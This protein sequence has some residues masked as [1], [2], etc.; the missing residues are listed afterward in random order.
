MQN[1]TATV[2]SL[3]IERDGAVLLGRRS[4][5]KDHA[6]GEWETIS[7]RVE[8]S[9]TLVEAAQREALEE[10][11]LVVEVL[12]QLASFKFRR[13]TDIAETH[14]VTFHCRVREGSERL[15]D[16]HDRFAW[17]TLEQAKGYGLPEGLLQCIE[18]VLK[19]QIHDA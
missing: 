12:K 1:A 7:C 16:E 10:T 11:G 19:R 17:A 18:T 14:G 2:V 5:T 9:E 13:G 8:A 6:P 4:S 15:S 3:V